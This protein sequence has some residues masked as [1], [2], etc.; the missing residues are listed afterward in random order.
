MIFSSKKKEIYKLLDTWRDQNA[1]KQPA[2]NKIIS[3]KE[4]IGNSISKFFKNH[5]VH[6]TADAV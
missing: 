1:D 5:M 2:I 4:P 6:A 3:L